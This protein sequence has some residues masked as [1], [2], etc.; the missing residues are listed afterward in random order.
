MALTIFGSA[1]NAYKNAGKQIRLGIDS[2][3]RKLNAMTVA[4]DT[5]FY[6][7]PLALEVGILT[8]GSSPPINLEKPEAAGLMVKAIFH[9]VESV[10]ADA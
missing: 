7:V 8:L 6:T 2:D 9:A 4:T 5:G 3:R 1:S 10:A